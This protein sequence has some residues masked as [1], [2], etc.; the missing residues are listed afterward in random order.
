[1]ALRHPKQ[2]VGH[3]GAAFGYFVSYAHSSALHLLRRLTSRAYV[4][5]E[6]VSC[7]GLVAAD[8]APIVW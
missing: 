5:R 3:N 1:M 6:V 7:G 2:K 8:R 4:R